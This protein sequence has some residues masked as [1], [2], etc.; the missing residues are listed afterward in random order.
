MSLLPNVYL[1][2]EEPE[3]EDEALDSSILSKSTGLNLL[4]NAEDEEEEDEEFEP[5]TL[6]INEGSP[7]FLESESAINNNPWD[8]ISWMNYI[9]EV[10]NDRGGQLTLSE[11]YSKFLEQFPYSVKICKAYAKFSI[12][13][14]DY[15]Q[16]NYIFNTCL[17]KCRSV[18]L[19]ELYLQL[20]Q[21]KTVGS[22]S[23]K[24]H[25]NFEIEKKKYVGELER[26]LENVGMCCNS[27]SIWRQYI[28]FIND[29]PEIEST[30]KSQKID[31]LRKIYRRVVTTPL[32]LA[33]TC[34]ESTL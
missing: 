29:W 32:L 18:S 9:E 30:D 23:S 2:E 16:A 22:L 14:G 31:A 25:T 15:Q 28:D 17:M 21:K 8:L 26:A 33:S 4:M 13:T 5:H 7:E 27:G 11:A 12:D 3:E 6:K 24:Y 19:W 1:D 10:Q 34:F 20:I